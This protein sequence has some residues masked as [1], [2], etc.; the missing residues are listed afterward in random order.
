MRTDALVRLAGLV[1]VALLAVP[2][3][4]GRDY[5]FTN[6]TDDAPGSTLGLAQFL[7]P[8]LI[9]SSGAVAFTADPYSSLVPGIYTGSGNGLI[10]VYEGAVS[11]GKPRVNATTGFNDSGTVVFVSG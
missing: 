6:I 4:F 8:F 2:T 3:L 7:G 9:N 5:T 10:T 11:L 1:L